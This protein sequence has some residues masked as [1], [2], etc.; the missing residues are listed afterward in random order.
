MRVKLNKMARLNSFTLGLRVDLTRLN[1][2][3]RCAD[4][5]LVREN[6]GRILLT[7]NLLCIAMS[8]NGSANEDERAKKPSANY[9]QSDMA[10]DVSAGRLKLIL[11]QGF[12]D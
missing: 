9:C 1:D 6:L 7:L 8:G 11:L 12:V 3:A 4:L 10:D 2:V 5:S